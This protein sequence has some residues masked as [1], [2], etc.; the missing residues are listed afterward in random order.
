MRTP[1]PGSSQKGTGQ[2][3]HGGQDGSPQAS[4]RSYNDRIQAYRASGHRFVLIDR[5][6][7]KNEPVAQDFLD[8]AKLAHPQLNFLPDKLV[9]ANGSK[10]SMF[11][12]SPCNVLDPSQGLGT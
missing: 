10:R 1:N 5:I 11:T 6:K 8:V 3:T 7:S 4:S 9:N 12:W 2:G